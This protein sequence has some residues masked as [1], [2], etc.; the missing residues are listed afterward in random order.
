MIVPFSA[1]AQDNEGRRGGMFSGGRG[2]GE[3]QPNVPSQAPSGQNDDDNAR[4]RD[5]QARE[6]QRREQQQREN[7]ARENEQRENQA[8]E[9]QARENQARENQAREN[10]ERDNRARE[11][12]QQQQQRAREQEREQERAQEQ[13]RQQER[14]REQERQRNNDRRQREEQSRRDLDNNIQNNGGQGGLFNTLRERPNDGRENGRNR[15]TEQNDNGRKDFGRNDRDRDRN[16][17]DRNDRDRNNWDRDRDRGRDNRARNNWSRD[18]WNRFYNNNRNWDWDRR[19]WYE[20]KRF[21]RN[22][23]DHYRYRDPDHRWRGVF[24]RV[25]IQSY[26]TLPPSYYGL[27]SGWIGPLY[28]EEVWLSFDPEVY[29]ALPYAAR[30][31]H[32]QAFQYALYGP[33]G[34]TVSWRNGPVR[35]DITMMDEHYFGDEWC[36]DFVQTISTP[37]WRRTSDGRMCIGWGEPWRLVD[38]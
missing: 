28:D 4:E 2:R 34:R 21:G 24:P 6:N 19:E 14:A 27:R 29:D 3:P 5:N 38:Y 31:K 9:N 32:E 15:E 17:W 7:Q 10:Q 37:T 33:L 1:A 35:G 12:R 30:E 8:R 16:N 20:R 23:F 25:I 26:Y 11:E 22:R 36:R 18:D 13:Q